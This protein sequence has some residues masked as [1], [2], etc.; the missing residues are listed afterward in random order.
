LSSMHEQE[1]KELIRKTLRGEK[2]AFEMIVRNYQQPLLNYIGRMVGEREL[3]LD[4]TQ[5]VF[6]RAY[7]SLRSFEPKF[8]FSTWLYR[9]ASNLVIDYWRKKKIPTFSLSAPL[10]TESG[11]LTMDIPDEAPSVARKFELAELGRR[12]EGVLDQIPASFRQLFIWRHISGLSYEE[13]S[14]ITDLPV[15]TVK[16]RVFQAKEMIRRLLEE[17]P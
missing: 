6:V 15:G 10:S 17:N 11:D 3:A 1:E 9:I 14:E 13:M 12:I 16:N 7:S 5:E 8:K 2:R 4:F